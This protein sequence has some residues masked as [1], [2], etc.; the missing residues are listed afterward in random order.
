MLGLGH[1]FYSISNRKQSTAYYKLI[2]W[3]E[4]SIR[5]FTPVY[6]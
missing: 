6:L 5:R 3:T 1:W 2:N 4:G